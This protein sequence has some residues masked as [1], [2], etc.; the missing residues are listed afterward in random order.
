MSKQ[1]LVALVIII[2]SF[3]A[4]FKEDKTIS[5]PPKTGSSFM[6]VNMG[7]D[8]NTC[9][10]IN[11]D[12]STVV[13]KTNITDWHLRFDA[14]PTGNAILLNAGN[15]SMRIITCTDTSMLTPTIAPAITETWGFDVPNQLAD[16]AFLNN[17]RLTNAVTKNNVYVIRSGE[18]STTLAMYKI[19]L[20]HSDNFKYTIQ[21]DTITGTNPKTIDVFK[22]SN[23][24]FMYFTFNKGGEVILQE[25]KKTEW[26]ICFTKYNHPFYNN[27]PFL[28]YPVVGA[29]TNNFNTISAGDTSKPMAFEQVTPLTAGAFP[30]NNNANNIGYNWKKPDANYNF[31]TYP[32]YIYFLR[33][34]NGHL[35]KL[36]FVDFYTS[37]GSKGAPKFEFERLQ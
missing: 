6:Q 19:K 28:Y 37:S 5:L 3:T 14:R 25:P 4:C 11:L 2:V 31:I 15:G 20:I 10:Y 29:L 16:S 23:Y 17:N 26:D 34:Q 27:N 22:N 9:Y 36:H 24:N 13:A 8:Y 35:Y 12:S 7:T 21:Y 30:L 33:T 1:I 18:S 32:N